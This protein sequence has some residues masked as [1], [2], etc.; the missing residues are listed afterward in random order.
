VTILQALRLRGCTVTYVTC[1]GVF[2]DC[3]VLQP[4]NGAP[5]KKPANACLICQSSVAA[6]MANWGLAYRWLSRWLT[7]Q[8]FSDAAAWAHSFRG[9]DMAEARFGDWPI[10]AW[11]TSSVHK[12]LRHTALDVND[13]QV[14]GTFASYL[15]S[16]RLAA[17]GLSRLLDEEKPDSLLLFNGRMA[18]MRTALEL[19]KRRGIH[20]LVEER[21]FMPGHLTLLENRQCVDSGDLITLWDAWKNTPLTEPELNA[22]GKLFKDRWHGQKDTIAFIVSRQRTGETRAALTLDP[23]KPVWA[24]F[25]SNLDEAAGSGLAGGVFT[26]HEGWVRASVD[27][28]RRHPQIQLVIRVHPNSGSQRSFAQNPQELAFY[29]ALARDLPANVRLVRSDETLNSY[30]LAAIADLGLTW[31]TTLGVEMAALGKDVIRCGSLDVGAQPNLPTP[32]NPA[33]YERMLNERLAGTR[34]DPLAVARAAWRFA[35]LAFFRYAFPFPLVKQRDW[36]IGEMNFED[37][38]ALAPGKDAML[39]RICAHVMEGA[40]LHGDPPPRGADIAAAEADF[41][42]QWIAN[43]D[44]GEVAA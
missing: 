2:S 26:T 14:A 36:H 13:P 24:L 8:D 33:D 32:P 35:A 15:Y 17:V 9:Q 10:G 22:V 18:P 31:H 11:V 25:T 27:F 7:T 5:A 34:S 41:I 21:G 29:E 4:A 1:D 39:D 3:D 28:A 19:G 38:S 6:H 16:G 23:G 30:N 44:P 42:G 40:P 43:A 37:Y 20:T 12:H